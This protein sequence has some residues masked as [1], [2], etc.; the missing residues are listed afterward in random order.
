MDRGITDTMLKHWRWEQ[1][2]QGLAWLTFDKQGESTNTFSREALEELGTAL[3]AIAAAK[4]KGLVIRSAKEN[5]IAGADI[6]EF[7]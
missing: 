5:F 4:P 6:K 2:R 7:T 1:D 3:D